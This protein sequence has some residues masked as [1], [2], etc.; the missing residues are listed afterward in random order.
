MTNNNISTASHTYEK[1][2]FL[3]LEGLNVVIDKQK[4]FNDHFFRHI[5]TQDKIDLKILDCLNSDIKNIQ[6]LYDIVFNITLK[7]QIFICINIVVLTG[8][9]AYFFCKK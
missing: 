2:S 1:K 6:N 3:T 4:D 5:E 7:L 9:I 8:I